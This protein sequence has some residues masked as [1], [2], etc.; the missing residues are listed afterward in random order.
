MTKREA[1]YSRIVE[2]GDYNRM[3]TREHLYIAEADRDLRR[4]VHRYSAGKNKPAEVVEIGCG[5]VRLTPLL[6]TIPNV[7]VTA[8]DHD[9]GWIKAA[10]EIVE[11][12]GL[13]VNLVCAD[14][15]SYQH[16]QPID[17][18][19]S[20]G[21]HH[22]IE[23]GEPT[24]RYLEN[25]RRQLVPGGTYTI[26][27][28]MVAYYASPEERYVRLCIWYAHIIGD[29]LIHG[30]GQL[31]L[32][33]IET[34]LDDLFEGSGTR[35]V[36]DEEQISLVRSSVIVIAGYAIKDELKAAEKLA[37]MLL[38]EIWDQQSMSTIEN[39]PLSRGDYKVCFSVLAEEVAVAGFRIREAK[40]I[41]PI[42]TIGGFGIYTLEP[43]P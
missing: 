2:A 13:P 14:I 7:H 25:I 31:A 12:Q 6:S 9:P 11:Q 15:E 26:S 8:L 4:I 35:A 30:Y 18:A 10:E 29:A 20:Q 36:K 5:P 33:E 27:D 21:S 1:T 32:A 19:V 41:G 28:E 16:P 17:I 24:L 40:T 38:Q 34:L 43:I 23:K 37:D 39:R 42:E 3:M 22:H